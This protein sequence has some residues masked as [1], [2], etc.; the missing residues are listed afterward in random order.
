MAV[1]RKDRDRRR[2]QVRYVSQNDLVSS[3]DQWTE[4]QSGQNHRVDRGEDKTHE[5]NDPRPV[6]SSNP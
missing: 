2:T 6:H 4:P 5:L 3:F 1:D